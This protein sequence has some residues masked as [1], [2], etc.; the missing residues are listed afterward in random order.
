MVAVAQVAER[1][2]VVAEV[3]GSKPV[4]HPSQRSITMS[5]SKSVSR[6]E[7]IHTLVYQAADALAEGAIN[8]GKGL[9]FLLNNGWLPF[10]IE[11][12]I[13]KEMVR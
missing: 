9:D 6:E 7:A 8:A 4:G 1:R 5:V 11:R 10:D 3:A 2:V 12:A 13:K